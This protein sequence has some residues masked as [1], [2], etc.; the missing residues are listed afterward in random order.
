MKPLWEEKLGNKQKIKKRAEDLNIKSMQ[1]IN[2]EIIQGKLHIPDEETMNCEDLIQKYQH[3]DYNA[4]VNE[5]IKKQRLQDAQRLRQELENKLK[6]IDQ[7]IELLNDK[8]IDKPNNKRK[9]ID[10]TKEQDKS[11]LK[12]L[13]QLHKDQKMHELQMQ[14]KMEK[15]E[16]QKKMEEQKNRLQ[17]EERQNQLQEEKRR[18]IEEKLQKLKQEQQARL[19]QI[20]ESNQKYKDIVHQVGSRLH[21]KKEQEYK[22]KMNLTLEEKKKSLAQIRKLNT[23]KVEEIGEHIKKYEQLRKQ[24]ELERKEQS[25]ER[26]FK[27]KKPEF[28]SEIYKKIIQ[29]EEQRLKELKEEEERKK[30]QIEKKK[31]YAKLILSDHKK[32]LKVKPSMKNGHSIIS[33]DVNSSNV[34][35]PVKQSKSQEERIRLGLDYM[36]FNKKRAKK[37]EDQEN[38]TGFT[39]PQLDQNSENFERNVKI[40]GDNKFQTRSTSSAALSNGLQYQSFQNQKDEKNS[41]GT[42]RSTPSLY[43]NS[44]HQN[45]NIY[46]IQMKNLEK[47]TKKYHEL[48]KQKNQGDEFINNKKSIK[49]KKGQNSMQEINDENMNNNY[50]QMS[51]SQ[52]KKESSS[53]LQQQ[54]KRALERKKLR[55]LQEQEIAKN[56]LKQEKAKEYQNKQLKYKNDV[57]NTTDKLIEMAKQKEKLIELKKRDPYTRDDIEER[58]MVANLYMT[59]IK[60][61]LAMLDEKNN[62]KYDF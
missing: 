26:N 32:N 41:R 36:S 17:L 37:R 57:Q 56:R 62:E 6:T 4:I 55:E 50:S 42:N 1:K 19:K 18:K 33:N 54:Q 11:H 58:D 9:V 2:L 43:K 10:Y 45:M 22:N 61:K 52:D 40:H 25:Q 15:I 60:A 27:F 34:F 5:N 29:Q 12:F 28:E 38:N 59:S 21:V 16:Q 13:K 35:A 20:E 24:K 51:K 14:Q 46:E 49:Q 47:I 7:D 8:R 23:P 30:E 31:C 3:W 53:F 48:D 39:A 44:K